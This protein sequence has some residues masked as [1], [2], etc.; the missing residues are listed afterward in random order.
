M[1]WILVADI[2]G[3]NA[4]FAEVRD[5]RL[6]RKRAYPTG[7]RPLAEAAQAFIDD[8]GNP[9]QRAVFAAAGV[10]ES[11]R[12]DLTN[13]DQHLDE[14]ELATLTSL[15]QA[16]IINDFEAAAWSLDNI[17]NQQV[18]AIQGPATPPPGNR[19]VLGPGTGLGVG[20]LIRRRDTVLTVPGEGGHVGI[21]PTTDEDIEIFRAFER[22][23]P[24][25]RFAGHMRYEAEAFVSGTGL[26]HLYLSLIH[27]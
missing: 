15:K 19:I 5:G 11:G 23:W 27:I 2:G 17:D 7:E 8:A 12:V 1:P 25:T 21:S 4:R 3:T 16:R 18:T 26:P 22:H 20:A 24:E 10:V 13:S 9:P 6:C 14:R